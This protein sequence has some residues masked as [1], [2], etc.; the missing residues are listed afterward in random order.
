MNMLMQDDTRACRRAGVA[1][2]SEK[3]FE[4]VQPPIET[5][6]LRFGYCALSFF[7][8]LKLPFSGWSQVSATPSTE[9]E[10][11]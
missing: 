3:N 1:A 10:A 8:W 2:A 4:Y 11:S 9:V 7:N 6:I 5:R